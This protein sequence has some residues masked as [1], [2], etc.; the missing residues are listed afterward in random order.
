MVVMDQGVYMFS[1]FPNFKQIYN[2]LDH[3][4]CIVHTLHILCVS[5]RVEYSKSNDFI[6]EMKNVLLKAN[7]CIQ[8]YRDVTG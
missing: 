2:T 7:A 6:S 3:V 4:T 5:V 8:I 1:A